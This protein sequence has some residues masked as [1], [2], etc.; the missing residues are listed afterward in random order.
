M[1]LPIN[2]TARRPTLTDLAI[3]YGCDKWFRHSYM[4]TYESLFAHRHVHRLLEVGIGYEGLMTPFVP[5]YVHGASLKMW[6]EYWPNANIYACDIREDALVNEGRI[7]SWYADQSRPMD[8]ERLVAN[9]GG[10]LDVVIDDG[11]HEYEHQIITATALLPW[12]MP[13]GGVYVIEDT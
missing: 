12:V 8:L 9:C 5:F 1:D 7:K 3:K 2:N 11:S 4:P 6:S 10:K 13:H